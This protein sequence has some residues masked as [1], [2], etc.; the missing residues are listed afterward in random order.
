MS[1]VRIES[2]SR[3]RVS[4]CVFIDA[5]RTASCPER[6][7]ELGCRWSAF[8]SG[9]RRTRSAV[10]FGFRTIRQPNRVPSGRA[11]SR[12]TADIGPDCTLLVCCWAT[13][14][15]FD[16]VAAPRTARSVGSLPLGWVQQA[17]AIGSRFLLMTSA[18]PSGDHAGRLAYRLYRRSIELS[19]FRRASDSS[20]LT[21]APENNRHRAA[22][23]R[24]CRRRQHRTYRCPSTLTDSPS[25]TKR[26]KTP[27]YCSGEDK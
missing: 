26:A 18:R 3:S 4:G 16:F 14:P 5:V 15:G 7:T 10:A 24:R 6:A 25:H 8:P 13:M 20:R 27:W 22:I 9:E 12:R 21:L 17:G 11:A 19:A 1:K 23:G 2:R